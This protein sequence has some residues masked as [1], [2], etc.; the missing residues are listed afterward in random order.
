[1]TPL[2][3]LASQLIQSQPE[4]SKL[5]NRHGTPSTSTLDF[6]SFGVFPEP[7]GWEV[8]FDTDTSELTYTSPEVPVSFF[9]LFSLI[10]VQPTD[11][12]RKGNQ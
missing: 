2:V 7:L 1:M 6:G 11:I 12:E 8:A 3:R 4:Y 9:L 5:S 10:L